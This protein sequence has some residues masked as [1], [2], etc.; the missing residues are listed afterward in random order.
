MRRLVLSI[1]LVLPL[2]VSA[3]NIFNENAQ[4][5]LKL[6]M[7]GA[8]SASFQSACLDDENHKIIDRNECSLEINR[9]LAL[10]DNVKEFDEHSALIKNFKQKNQL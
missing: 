1:L 10:I 3:E 2:T 4:M 7:Q 9:Q 8:L 5:A 6:L